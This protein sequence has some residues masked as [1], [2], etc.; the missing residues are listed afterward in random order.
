MTTD[1]EGRVALVVGVGP[2]IGRAC[3]VA[4]AEAGADVAIAARDGVRLR[5]IAGEVA[6]DTGRRVEPFAAD[7]AT[8]DGCA[9]LVDRVVEA[10]GGIDVLTTVAAAGSGHHP[11][12]AVDWDHW[13]HGFQ[14]NVVSAM[15]LARLAAASMRGRGGGSIVY[16]STLATKQHTAGSGAYAATKLA[17]VTAAK[18][19]AK[20][21]GR[22]GVRVNVVTPGFVAGE[23]LD[24]MFERQAAERD[25]SADELAA[26]AA[27]LTALGRLVEDVEIARAVRFL[28]S[29]EAS[30]ITGVELPVTA[31]IDP[32]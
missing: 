23:R 4:L 9:D 30:G 16:I 29:D 10:F 5:E 15:E 12:D 3:A 1:M 7:I 26:R 20:E 13:R 32:L 2:G 6:K 18:T 11:F 28:A 25:R 24:A 21:F 8:V 27:G 19:M 22:D 31:G 14:I 17:G